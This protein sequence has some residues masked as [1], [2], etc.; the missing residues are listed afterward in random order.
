VANKHTTDYRVLFN[1]QTKLI[2]HKYPIIG[3]WE[4]M[5]SHAGDIYRG[6]SK[7]TPDSSYVCEK[8][9]RL[10]HYMEDS[11]INQADFREFVY[12]SKEYKDPQEIQ[13]KKDSFRTNLTQLRKKTGQ[14]VTDPV[15]KKC[16]ISS[17]DMIGALADYYEKTPSDVPIKQWKAL[18]S[19]VNRCLPVKCRKE[20]RW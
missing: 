2:E 6:L 3:I 17:L 5:I 11:P 1:R 15:R 16:L 4:H 13:R 12:Y 18:K 14:E 10:G 7:E 19:S 9:N 8:V 20:K